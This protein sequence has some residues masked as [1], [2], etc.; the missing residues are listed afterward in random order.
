M[1][2]VESV[3][4]DFSTTLLW[5]GFDLFIFNMICDYSK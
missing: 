1:D 5:R 4:P 2:F 3:G